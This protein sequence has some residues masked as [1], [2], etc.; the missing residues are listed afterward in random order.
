RKL[1][2]EPAHYLRRSAKDRRIPD[3]GVALAGGKI[4]NLETMT[5]PLTVTASM[6]IGGADRLAIAPFAKDTTATM[7]SNWETP[8]FGGGFLPVT[9]NVGD[10]TEDGFTADWNIPYLA[11]GVPGAG[12]DLDLTSLTQADY[13]DVAV[14]FLKSVS[15]YQSVERALKYAIMFIGLLF[16]AYFLFETVSEARAHPAQYVLVGLAQTIFYLLLLAFAERIGFD[17]A[18]MIAST[19]TVALTSLYA[20]SV[21]RS[22][23]VGAQAFGVAGVIYAFAYLLMR[24]QENALIAGSL[25]SFTA[26][27]ATM[28]FTRNIDWYGSKSA[29]QPTP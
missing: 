8:S 20:G 1:T 6:M 15:P 17:G 26:I 12:A 18:F 7:R 14:R 2:M 5:A 13:R 28:Y 21:F 9:H 24:A 4:A 3:A 27:A 10:K 11:R 23:V 22:R 19:M 25:A 29:S 16:L